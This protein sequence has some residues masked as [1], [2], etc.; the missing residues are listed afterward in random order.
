MSRLERRCRRLLLA[1]PQP[2]R[3]DRGEEIIRLDPPPPGQGAMVPRA[4]GSAET[5]SSP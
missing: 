3:T 2:Y 1:Y 4:P 5:P